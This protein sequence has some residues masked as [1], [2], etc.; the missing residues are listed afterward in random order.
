MCLEDPRGVAKTTLVVL[1]VHMCGTF[2]IRRG[3]E[4]ILC[5]FVLSCLVLSRLLLRK[6][7][8]PKRRIEERRKD[9]VRREETYE[10]VERVGWVLLYI[11]R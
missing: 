4:R 9:E 6:L 1:L 8:K 3:V 11:A 5:S 7:T 2:V 10:V